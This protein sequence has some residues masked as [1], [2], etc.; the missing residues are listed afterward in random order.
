MADVDFTRMADAVAEGIKK[1]RTLGGIGFGGTPKDEVNASPS[2]VMFDKGLASTARAFQILHGNTYQLSASF[3][4]LLGGGVF[5]GVVTAMINSLGDMSKTF[6]KMTDIGENFGG[7]IFKMQQLAGESGLSMEQFTSGITKASTVI[8]QMSGDQVK[9]IEGFNKYQT[10]VRQTLK[11]NGYYGMSLTELNDMQAEYA[12]TLRQTYQWDQLTDKQR[13][14]STVAFISTVSAMAAATGKSREALAKQTEEILKSP[15]TAA[16][17]AQLGDARKEQ[18]NAVMAMITGISQEAGAAMGNLIGE[19]GRFYFTQFGEQAV[20]AG[21]TEL[22][23][24]L[25]KLQEMLTHDVKDIDPQELAST[26][27]AIPEE[28]LKNTSRLLDFPPGSKERAAGDYLLKFAQ[29][30]AGLKPEVIAERMKKAQEDWASGET[31]AILT[32]EST[33]REVTG[34]FR[35]GFYKSIIDML[36]PMKD[37]KRDLAQLQDN[38]DAFSGIIKTAGEEIGWVFG[39]VLTSFNHLRNGLESVLEMFPGMQPKETTDQEGKK[40]T[41]KPAHNLANKIIGA[42]GLAGIGLLIMRRI[43]RAFSGLKNMY[44]DAKNVIIKGRPGFGG[45]L[46]DMGDLIPDK[47]Q[48]ELFEKT[49]PKGRLGRLW[50]GAKRLPGRLGGGRVGGLLSGMAGRAGGLLKGAPGML[51]DMVEGAGDA[52]K[53]LFK[54]L[55]TMFSK[56]LGGVHS[57]L[58]GLFQRIPTMLGDMVEGAGDTVMGLFKNIPTMLGKM[59]EG[60]GGKVTGLFADAPGMF[61][62]MFKSISRAFTGLFKS[63]P[64][65]LVKGIGSSFTGLFKGGFGGIVNILKGMFQNFSWGSMFK[66]LGKG[67]IGFVLGQVIGPLLDAIMAIQGRQRESQD[68]REL[69]RLWFYDWIDYP[70]CRYHGRSDHRLYRR[71]HRRELR[72]HHGQHRYLVRG[73]RQVGGQSGAWSGQ[74]VH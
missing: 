27:T 20:T 14:S 5:A 47:R 60:V 63:A 39:F 32:F 54:R 65:L 52:V 64:A 57:G 70:W 1:S 72:R 38:L 55:P 29:S 37:G 21:L 33:M 69:R 34:A 56:M 15:R 4:K 19:K 62:S 7:S 26:L 18:T 9:A 67:I 74:L 49:R 24:P 73:C 2:K 28:I 10:S 23:A 16:A 44:V 43:F 46:G 59:V 53:G 17:L 36:A 6:S 51:G 68:R 22:S 31:T 40:V 50:A 66:G 3:E 61:S 8:T 11:L 71:D 35:G 42:I 12:D 45:G 13:E 25:D 58:P 41:E 30:M 48:G